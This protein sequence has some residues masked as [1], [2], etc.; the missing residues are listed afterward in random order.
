MSYKYKKIRF[1]STVLASLSF[2]ALS[3]SAL[4][5]FNS[6]NRAIDQTVAILAHEIS[7]SIIKRVDNYLGVPT[8]AVFELKKLIE[9]KHI[10]LQDR[11]SMMRWLASQSKI[12]PEIIGMII[13]TKNGDLWGSNIL[14][15]G[16]QVYLAS[17]SVTKNHLTV[18][19]VNQ[20]E[21]LGKKMYD[22]GSYDPRLRPWF[23]AVSKAKKPI[24]SPIFRQ[25]ETGIPVIALLVPMYKDNQL[26][27]VI[28]S[29]IT[30]PELS[31]FLK[32]SN[33]GQKGISY[34]ADHDHKL[35]ASS[36]PVP[37]A[38][39]AGPMK[40]LEKLRPSLVGSIESTLS[41][42]HENV[43]KKNIVVGDDLFFVNSVLY[44]NQYGLNW[45]VTTA[46]TTNDFLPP[47]LKKEAFSRKFALIGAVLSFIMV[48]ASIRILLKE[49]SY[50]RQIENNLKKNKEQYRQ[51]LESTN[52]TPWEFDF[53]KQ[54]FDY[55]APQ[56]VDLLGY[57][58]DS[59]TDLNSWSDRIHP[60][61]REAA[62][63]YC[64]AQTAKGENHDFE[65]RMI[66]VDGRTVWIRDVVAMVK[67]KKRV[68][69]LR[70]FFVDISAQK[71]MENDL[72]LSKESAE[73]A[74]KAKSDFLATMSHE[75]RTPM[76]VIQGSV[77]LLSR[78]GMP[79]EHLK[80]VE[81]IS[82][83]TSSLLNILDDILDLSKIEDQKVALVN[84][85]Y[86][87]P[88]LLKHLIDSMRPNAEKKGLDL[89]CHIDAN[90]PNYVYGDQTR[91]RQVLWNLVSNA[92]K[93]TD[94]GEIKIQA[95]GI[96]H[97][98]EIKQLEFLVI[99]TGIGIPQDSLS[100]IFDPFVQVD[101][102]TTRSR[103][104]TGLGLSICKKIINLMGG[105]I[106]VKSTLGKGTV[107][108]LLIPFKSGGRLT[109]D[110]NEEIILDPQ[111]L[112]LLLVED[113]PISQM[114]IESLLSEEGYQVKVASSGKEALEK[115]AVHEFDV[116]L[117]DLRMPEMDGFATSK[118]IRQSPDKRIAETK[119]VAFTGDVMKET[120]QKC[121]DIGMDSVVA[122]PINIFEINRVLISLTAEESTSS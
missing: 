41:E 52:F 106:T 2:I 51:L 32:T 75:I 48:I 67:K 77:E 55:V 89:H 1:I 9:L 54:H 18:Y 43:D 96:A 35:I 44:S 121:L 107:F 104:G 56:I 120:V 38:D 72:V 7:G 122:K 19:Q 62:V 36:L 113:E 8:R 61:D 88:E 103:Q 112:S 40:T 90:L 3:L 68:S 64:L 79:D 99:D 95:R 53:T 81:N 37:V 71:K 98:G 22:S 21:T 28:N 13:S 80:L 108:K 115:I 69:G 114:V 63:A 105:T 15:D 27:A 86:V 46:L 74:S 94:E 42:S 117:M 30:L 57:S 65:Y 49:I 26:Q 34:I 59:W 100:A 66:T 97:E 118:L 4:S 24:W 23:L 91:F 45:R 5:F 16:Q 10:D 39:L 50:R 29:T 85:D 116:I 93:F 17:D 20:D 73:S 31:K 33:L 6:N 101:A 58:Q 12:H 78:K 47:I 25:K 102:S 76:N 70:G 111:P 92:I 109:K 14:P 87:L 84:A 60:D 110:D 82:Y 83:G 11:Q 119:I